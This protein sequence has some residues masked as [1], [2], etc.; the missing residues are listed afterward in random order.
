MKLRLNFN[1]LSYV[2]EFIFRRNI[3]IAFITETWLKETVSDGVVD[4][5]D[6]AVLRQDRKRD[7]HGGVCAYIKEGYCRYK[8]LKELNYC[9]EHE[10]LW[11]HLTPT[12]LPRGFSCIIA[13]VIYHPPKSDDRSFREHLFQSLTLVESKYPNCGIL[14]TGDFNRLDIGCL[15]RH[16]RLNQIVKEHTRNDATLDL[17]LTNMHDHYSPPQPFAPLGLSDHDVVVA[18][19]LHGK[20]INNT[21][22][23][24]TERD[25]R[26]SSKAS[27]G[28]FLNG[29]HWS[30]LFSPLEGCKEMW[31][32]FSKAARTGLD[33]LMPEK[34]FRIC[35]A[36]AP[37]MT[38]RVKALILKRQKAFTMHGPE[39]SQFKYLRNLV[40]RERKACRVRY[41]ESKVQQ[42]KGKNP[43]KWWDEVKRLSGA[44]SRNGDLVKL[45]NTEQF[46]S[47]SGPDQAN[48]INSAFLEPL[49]VYKLHEPLAHSPWRTHPNF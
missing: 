30:I 41:Y 39:S 40:N 22:K 25:L 4:I 20:R 10:S 49:Q 2:R 5:P 16:F 47:L 24:I 33:I 12:R 42:L 45:I 48:A 21:K 11:L 15:L 37:W 9:D 29:I 1:I 36:D 38:Q 8:H 13:A 34:Q 28:R 27:M 35:T 23:T 19:P 7:S 6:F 46:S 18:T 31:N 14:V 17:I 44:K 3:T 43:K 26:A 32:V